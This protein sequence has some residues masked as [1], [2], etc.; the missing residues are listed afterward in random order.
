MSMYQDFITDAQLIAAAHPSHSR[1]QGG[2][3]KR[4]VSLAVYADGNMAY[5]AVGSCGHNRIF[6][7]EYG[8][9]I[10]GSALVS[11]NWVRDEEEA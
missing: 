10:L 8:T 2:H 1:A 7:R 4:R 11:C 5:F 3:D 9:R 6:A